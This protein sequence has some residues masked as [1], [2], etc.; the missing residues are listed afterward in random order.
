MNRKPLNPVAHGIADYV[1]SAANIAAPTLLHLNP[2]ATKLFT[3][4][5]GGMLFLNGLTNTP[6][7]I[8][9]ELSFEDHRKADLVLLAGMSMLPLLGMIRKN[10]KTLYYA[11]GFLGLAAVN[12]LLTDYAAGTKN[13]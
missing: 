12:Y 7:G 4:L 2:K 11:L 1:L 5:S 6:V 8:K 3:T 9:K 10:K 13:R